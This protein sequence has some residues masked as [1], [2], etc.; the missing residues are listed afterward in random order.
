LLSSSPRT[1]PTGR[2]EIEEAAI[3]AAADQLA[4][5][6]PSRMTV[7]GVAE[8]AGVHHALVHRHLQTKERVIKSALERMAAESFEEV[9][10]R[11]GGQLRLTDYPRVRRYVIAL[12]RCLIE[13]PTLASTQ[14]SFPVLEHLIDSDIEHGLDRETAAARSVAWLCAVFGAELFGPH[15][16]RAAGIDFDADDGALDILAS[17]LNPRN[18]K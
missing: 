17:A 15:L 10:G 4:S 3:I 1:K 8:A 11:A 6:G 12:A 7:R 14:S 9:Q 13:D 5:L 18:H 16:A 2:V